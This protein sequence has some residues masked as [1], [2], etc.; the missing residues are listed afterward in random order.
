M[1]V[2]GESLASCAAGTGSVGAV[3]SQL[4]L[5]GLGDVRC[6]AGEEVEGVEGEHLGAVVDSV[7]AED[8]Y[9][10]GIAGAGTGVGNWGSEQVTEDA[11]C[12]CRFFWDDADG[13]VC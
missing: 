2:V 3:I 1:S 6:G 11:L 5:A 9:P 8:L 10:G 7:R 13:G 4:M 12:S